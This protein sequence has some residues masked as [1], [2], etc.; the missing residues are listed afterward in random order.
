MS[1]EWPNSPETPKSL[2]VTAALKVPTVIN[3]TQV[4]NTPAALDI[5]KVVNAGATQ[6]SRVYQSMR[7]S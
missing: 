2:R 6:R 3:I 7:I 5:Q 4:L 1:W